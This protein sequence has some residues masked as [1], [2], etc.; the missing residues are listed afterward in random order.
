MAVDIQAE[1]ARL[2]EVMD[3]IDNVNIFISE[4]AGV[5]DIVK[6][7][8][9]AGETVPRDAF[10]HVKLDAVNPGQWFGKQFAKLLN[11]EK[12]LIQKSGYYSRAAASNEADLK[13][14]LACCDKAVECALAGI[15][16]VIGEDENANNELR[17]CEFPRIAGGKP[18]DIDE[19]WFGELLAD[20]GQTKGEKVEVSH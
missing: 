11:A 6:E 10:G 4:G 15:G 9:A 14:I 20:I 2:K 3:D 13:L 17:A 16:G 5:E 19:P 1:A 8:E 18:F 7:M 12:V